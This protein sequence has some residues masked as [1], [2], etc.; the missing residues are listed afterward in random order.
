[1]KYEYTCIYSKYRYAAKKYVQ[2][3]EQ[4]NVLLEINRPEKLCSKIYKSILWS[5][6]AMFQ[7]LLLP[8]K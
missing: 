5:A 6:P 8:R 2:D 1:M 3:V 7:L 4:K